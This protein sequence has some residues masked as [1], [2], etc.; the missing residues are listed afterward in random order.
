MHFRKDE[1]F[2]KSSVLFTYQHSSLSW[3]G[4]ET[5][6]GGDKLDSMLNLVRIVIDYLAQFG[7]LGKTN[8]DLLIKFLF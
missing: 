4:S 7:D 1:I 6:I 2:L 5:P 8:Y 3:W